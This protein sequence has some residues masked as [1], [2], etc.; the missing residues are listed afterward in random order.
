MISDDS[1]LD[2]A[3]LLSLF[4]E[5]RRS[6]GRNKPRLP[7]QC[8]WNFFL[9]I[10][11][12][13]SHREGRL[14]SISASLAFRR[15][16]FLRSQR[17][18][19]LKSYRLGEIP[20]LKLRGQ[21]ECHKPLNR[22]A[23]N[24]SPVL[25]LAKA[26]THGGGTSTWIPGQL[27]IL[28]FLLQVA[29]VFQPCNSSCWVV[30]L[31][32]EEVHLSILS[33]SENM[34]FFLQWCTLKPLVVSGPKLPAR[35]AHFQRDLVQNSYNHHT[36]TQM[37]RPIKIQK[38]NRFLLLFAIIITDSTNFNYKAINQLCMTRGDR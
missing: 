17:R 27:S 36:S 33:S 25:E 21:E 18:F 15:L 29:A 32:Q 23:G 20:F 4:C 7:H 3:S 37:S 5:T 12:A 26:K 9:I 14:I 30:D 34:F 1:T 38:R 8:P 2:F 16:A 28:I 6:T 35:R 11:H 22:L 10:F 24:Q 13:D 31:L 19:W